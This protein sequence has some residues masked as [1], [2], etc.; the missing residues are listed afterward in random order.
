[1]V[2]AQPQVPAAQRWRRRK[3][4]RPGEILNA[5]LRCFAERGFAATRLDD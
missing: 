2:T 3:E 4:A 5:A 1:M